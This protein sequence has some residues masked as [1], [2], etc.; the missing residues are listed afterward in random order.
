MNQTEVMLWSNAIILLKEDMTADIQKTEAINLCVL[1]CSL[2]I[3]EGLIE[4]A[5]WGQEKQHGL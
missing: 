5:T 4:S 3:K 1:V 2:T